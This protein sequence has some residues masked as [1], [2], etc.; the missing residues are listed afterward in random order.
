MQKFR[1][2]DAQMIDPKLGN[3][4]SIQ[5]TGK[6][7]DMREYPDALESIEDTSEDAV[8][9]SYYKDMMQDVEEG[10]SKEEFAKKYPASA[11]EYDAIKKEIADMNE[12]QVDE[13][14]MKQAQIEVPRLGRQV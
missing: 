5:M 10:M 7:E 3:K 13:G 12:S 6:M 8:Q 4:K 11:N 9:E 1:P 14:K 2:N